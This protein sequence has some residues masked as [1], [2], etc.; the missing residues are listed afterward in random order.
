MKRTM[1]SKMITLGI[2]LLATVALAG[3][4]AA[5]C[6]GANKV[7]D[8]DSTCLD[9]SWTGVVVSLTNSCGWRIRTEIKGTRTLNNLGIER[10]NQT[11]FTHPRVD[12]NS[13]RTMDYSYVDDGVITEVS[14]CTDDAACSSGTASE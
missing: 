12:A 11:F 9:A 7:S 14:C 2:A 3:Q 1:K 5:L 8:A 10:P 4:A 13:S 6:E